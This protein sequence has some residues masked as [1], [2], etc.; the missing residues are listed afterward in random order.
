MK[1]KELTEEEF[2]ASPNGIQFIAVREKLNI[3][4]PEQYYEMA[5]KDHPEYFK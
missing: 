4:V 1:L 3:E 2:N 5:K